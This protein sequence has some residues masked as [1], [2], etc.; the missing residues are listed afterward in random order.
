MSNLTAWIN[1]TLYPALFDVIPSAFPEHSF[2]EF[3]GGWRSKT[4]LNGEPHKD[5]ADKTVITKKF[6]SIFSPH[7][8][9]RD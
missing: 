1:D 3:S 5:R 6:A 4:Y 9:L 7:T 8:A 2:Q